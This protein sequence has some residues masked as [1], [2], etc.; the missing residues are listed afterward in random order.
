MTKGEKIA[1]I[2]MRL[3]KIIQSGK[4]VKAQGVVRKLHRQLRNLKVAE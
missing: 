4:Y 2:E 1:A 3:N